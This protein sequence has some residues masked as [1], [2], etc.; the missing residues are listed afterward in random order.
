MADKTPF[1]VARETLKQLTQRKLPPTPMNYQKIYSEIAQLPLDPPFP[2]D[3]LREIVAAL[4]SKTPG[5]QKQRGLMESA[6][7]QLNWEGV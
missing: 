6:I 4:P 1:E 2:V 7:N 5:Q 3:R